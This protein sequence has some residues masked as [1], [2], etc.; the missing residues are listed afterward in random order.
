MSGTSAAQI[1]APRVATGVQ[2][3]AW[4]VLLAL[5]G[6]LVLFGIGDLFVGAPFDPEIALGLTGLTHAELQAES[7][8]G[9]LLLDYYTRGGGIS[10]AVMGLALVIILALP[11]R[12][13]QRWAWWTMWLFPAWNAAV[14][15]LFLAFGTAPGEALP[16]PM[17][18]AP[19]LGAAAV[20]AL[21]VDRSRFSGGSAS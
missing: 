13:G 17:V 15:A 18:S 8:A 3:V 5:A 2:R 6:L 1:E 4:W 10:L 16:P 12:D 9:Y 11:Y 19:I 21:L 7:T 20:V 14:F